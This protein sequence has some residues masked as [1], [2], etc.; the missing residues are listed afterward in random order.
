ME[1]IPT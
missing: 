1:V